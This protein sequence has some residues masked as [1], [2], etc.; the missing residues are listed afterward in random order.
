MALYEGFVRFDVK[1][2]VRRCEICSW[3]AILARFEFFRLR[4]EGRV[5]S[6]TVLVRSVYAGS[7]YVIWMCL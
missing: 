4:R 1:F 5:F 3:H 6:L 7:C 2:Q